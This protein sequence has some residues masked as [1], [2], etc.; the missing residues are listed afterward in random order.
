[1]SAQARLPKCSARW[2]AILLV[3]AIA[4][5][6]ATLAVRASSEAAPPERVWP[7]PP[8]PVRIAFVRSIE[9][10]ADA[11]VRLS[12]WSKLGNLITGGDKGNENFV[13]PFGLSLDEEGNVCITD[14]GAAAVC[15]W[16]RANRKW[17]RWTEIGKLRF[18]LPV[19]IAKRGGRLYVADSGLNAVL[20]FDQRPRLLRT[21]TNNL[22][23][24]SGVAVSSDVL[25]VADSQQHRISRYSLSGEYISSFG[26]RGA[27]EGEMNFPTHIWVSPRG[28][29]LVT[30]SMNHRVLAFDSTGKF[31]NTVGG[32]GDG[33]G[34]FSRP[35]GI[36]LDADRNIYV[37]DG[38]SD[39]VQIFNFQGQLLLNIGEPGSGSGQFWLP[40]GIA[41]DRK[42]AIFIAD[43]YNRRLQ[44]LQYL[45][46]P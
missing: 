6:G 28:E 10:P 37:V 31:I 7:L 40:N 34:L 22:G 20:I 35:K 38:L 33:P 27:A 32:L 13:K 45:G 9:R 12:G 18:A 16:D 42:G 17:Y 29:V 15:F 5:F 4:G 36:A 44:V 26:R 23:R 46:P 2:A 39:R 1:M 19:S 3:W 11:G 25:F 30:D 41:V 8:D 43:S 24:P 21:I 14:T